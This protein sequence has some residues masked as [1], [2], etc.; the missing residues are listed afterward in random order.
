MLTYTIYFNKHCGVSESRV[1][2]E[3]AIKDKDN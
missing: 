1:D 2:D 3:R